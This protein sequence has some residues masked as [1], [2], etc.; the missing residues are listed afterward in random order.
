[1]THNQAIQD[2]A[3]FDLVRYANCW[4]DADIL[5]EALAV[6]Q[7]D[8]C[9]SIASAG[10]NSLALL[11]NEPELVVACD[12]SPAQL[13]CVEV[14]LAAFAELSHTDMLAFLGFRHC[15]HRLDLFTLLRSSLSPSAKRYFDRNTKHIAGGLVHHG[16][17][18]R[19]VRIFSNWILPLTHSRKTLNE[20]MVEKDEPA[21]LEFYRQR[22]NTRR[23]RLLC[24]IFC[25]R[26]VLGRAGRDPEFMRFVEGEVADRILQRAEEG[27][28][29]VPTHD[30]PFLDY[31]ATGAFRQA[32][33]FYARAENFTR[34]RKNLS[35][36]K[37]FHGAVSDLFA[38]DEMG[39]DKF[40][41]SDIF[42]YM[43]RDLFLQTARLL[44]EN[45]RP[46]SRLAYWNMLV[47]REIA[48]HWPD[49]VRPLQELSESCFRR[50]KAFFY[51]AFH[52]DIVL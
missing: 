40:N 29:K 12:L 15:E 34:I 38:S 13:A 11:V 35:R 23:W 27:L 30:N 41:L 46:S 17:F 7:G 19:Y 26:F 37:L 47:P 31:I 22:W 24:R 45:A 2:R 9:L 5:L 4:E 50:D 6:K 21:R 18:E 3:A 28:T 52:V 20:L 43:S 16:K 42:E 33:P 44:I 49:R 36:L 48:R 10:D 32:L 1:M 8:R 39:F 14:R 51:Q 25:S